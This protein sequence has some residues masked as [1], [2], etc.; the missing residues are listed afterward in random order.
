MPAP[1]PAPATGY[2]TL[3]FDPAF[4][5]ML[6]RFPGPPRPA[7]VVSR[8]ERFRLTRH[9][10]VDRASKKALGQFLTS[11][12][13][14]HFAASLFEKPND[15]VRLLDAG[16]GAGALLAA[17]LERF[18]R[19]E[20]ADAVETDPDMLGPLSGVLASARRRGARVR[21]VGDCFLRWGLDG[22]KL[23][24]MTY[25]HAVLNPPYRRISTKQNVRMALR[26]A[27]IDVSNTYTAFVALALNRLVP[28]GELVAI[29]PRSFLA[30]PT[31]AAFR[32]WLIDRA[33]LTHVHLYGSRN[34]VF[35]DDDVLQEIVIVHLRRGAYQG[36]VT[37]STSTD[38]SMSDFAQT[39]HRPF[40]LLRPGD[41]QCRIRIPSH[42]ADVPLDARP[43]FDLTLSDFGVSVSTGPVIR[44]RVINHLRSGGS[45]KT[46]PL[47]HTRHHVGVGIEWPHADGGDEEA[48]S[49]DAPSHLAYPVGNYILV[50]R[51]AFK[52]GARR[53]MPALLRPEDLPAGTARIS[54]QDKFNVLHIDR[55][56]LPE[57]L[58]LGLTAYLG[59][60]L[61]D[62]HV[63]SLSGTTQINAV[64]LRTLP[65]P[66]VN[67]LCDLG[68]WA[69]TQDEWPDAAALD[70]RLQL[71]METDP[72][73][74]DATARP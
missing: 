24:R 64:D 36:C 73:R 18:G 37:V 13:T 33:A 30:G 59:T 21:Y 48:L 47:L 19:V 5:A 32:Q 2:T 70:D 58:A 14:A 4:L 68:T 71:M 28:G 25:T 26:Q 46:R 49:I 11:S 1:A 42:D 31:H 51:Y 54:V 57:A 50:R 16:A 17:V 43:G 67:I 69:A 15:L 38:D 63:R 12:A 22:R 60:T 65:C 66:S 29:L 72:A 41:P 3:T 23:D 53:V 62:A 56:G 9:A 55:G 35:G 6:P 74:E 8:P 45:G 40:A 10:N 20:A 34:T 61:V 7:S 39:E 27:G 52:E 44:S